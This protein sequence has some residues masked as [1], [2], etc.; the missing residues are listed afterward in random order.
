MIEFLRFSDRLRAMRRRDFP[1]MSE[2]TAP[3][4]RPIPATLYLEVLTPYDLLAFQR[5]LYLNSAA[6]LR[7]KRPWTWRTGCR[8][9]GFRDISITASNW[10]AVRSYRQPRTAGAAFARSYT[11]LYEARKR[12]AAELIYT[13]RRTSSENRHESKTL[14]QTLF[15][16]LQGSVGI[17]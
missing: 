10:W 14:R 15:E 4:K 3:V 1:Q 5:P 6:D 7:H 12:N 9:D 2:C 17:V 16:R 13:A 8:H 11:F